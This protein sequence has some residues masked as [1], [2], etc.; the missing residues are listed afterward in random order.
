MRI[1]VDEDLASR[2][3]LDRLERLLPGRVLAPTREASDEAVWQRAQEESAAVLTGNAVDFLALAG[4]SA[5]HAGLLLAYRSN[6][7]RRDLTAGSIAEAVV[8]I[9]EKY[10]DGVASMTLVVNSFVGRGGAS[11]H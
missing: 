1:L 10:P 5:S 6:D 7:R 8:R 4:R 2:E 9:V 3:L 11:G